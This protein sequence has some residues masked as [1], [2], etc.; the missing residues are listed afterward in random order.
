MCINK[1]YWPFFS[2]A[3]ILLC[4]SVCKSIVLFTP[5]ILSLEKL[6]GG[7]KWLH[8]W[9]AMPLPPLLLWATATC[10][11][12]LIHRLFLSLVLLSLAI[13]SDEVLQFW[14]SHRHF[15]WLDSFYGVA[16][17]VGGG[18]IYLIL[19]RLKY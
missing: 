3:L 16:G 13:V 2:Y 11:V 10:R 9:L 1:R 8:F 18:L 19:I 5:Y 14:L 7:D 15:D 12:P 17:I 6:M 4:L